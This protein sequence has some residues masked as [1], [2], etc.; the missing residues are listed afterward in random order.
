MPLPKK[1]SEVTVY[2]GGRAAPNSKA[3]NK[4]VAST[5][6][7]LGCGECFSGWD[8]RFSHIDPLIINPRTFEMHEQQF[9]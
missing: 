5:L 9:G 2:I 3:V 8:I 6:G 4:I 1:G 7:R